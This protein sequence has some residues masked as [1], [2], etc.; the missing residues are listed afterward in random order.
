MLRK[1]FLI[2]EKGEN[3]S[4]F[5]KNGFKKEFYEFKKEKNE[6]KNYLRHVLFVGFDSCLQVIFVILHFY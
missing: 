3:E 2:L 5:Q 6:F 4:L 1:V